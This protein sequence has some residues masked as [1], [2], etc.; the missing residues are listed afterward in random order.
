M[1]KWFASEEGELVQCP[2]TYELGVVV[3]V[4]TPPGEIRPWVSVMWS[5]KG[6]IGPHQPTHKYRLV[7]DAS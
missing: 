4:R 5:T 3:G 1:K 6:L 2:N 7:K